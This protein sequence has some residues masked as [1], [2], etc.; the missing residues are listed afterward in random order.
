MLVHFPV[1]LITVGFLFDLFAFF[2]KEQ[3][4]L[5]KT[6]YWL[7][8]AGAGGA[9]VA[10]L[11]GYFLTSQ[12]EGEAGMMREKHEQFATATVIIVIVGAFY[13][14]LS[15]YRKNDSASNTYIT[16]AL[17]LLACIFVS[18]TGYLGGSL[19]IDYMIGL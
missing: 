2:R 6:G 13:R 17:S 16:L 14:I 3:P 12:M 4:C 19:V 10:Y 9:I 8:L 5:S 18:V 11:T 15:S 1:A 7:S